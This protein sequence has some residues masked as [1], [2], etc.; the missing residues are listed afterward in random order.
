MGFLESFF[1]QYGYY[2]VFSVLFVCGLGVPI[3]EDITIISAGVISALGA[4]NPYWMVVVCYLGVITGDSLM[5]LL[6]KCFGDKMMKNRYFRR[7]LTPDL[8]ARVHA[9]FAR[10]NKRVLFFARFMPGLRAPIYILA[11]MNQKIRFVQ[12]LIIDSIATLV[13][14]PLLVYLG[15]YGASNADWL[16]SKIHEVKILS[17]VLVVFFIL[18][19]LYYYWRSKRRLAFF[20]KHRQ[21]LKELRNQEKRKHETKS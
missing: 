16:M 7:F 17:I 8:V 20:R 1:I 5:Y 21:L 19:L 12:F 13:S 11:G 14:A 18:V 2:A 6:G 10:Y 3:P 15:F 9:L 4:C